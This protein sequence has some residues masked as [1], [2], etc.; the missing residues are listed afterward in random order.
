MLLCITGIRDVLIITDYV[1]NLCKA[2]DLDH[3]G[4]SGGI[5]LHTV[6]TPQLDATNP[7]SW[8]CNIPFMKKAE[9][10]YFILFE[11][12]KPSLQALRSLVWEH[13]SERQSSPSTLPSPDLS[14]AVTLNIVN[15]STTDEWHEVV[16]DRLTIPIVGEWE[17]ELD[18][19]LK[20]I[21]QLYLFLHYEKPRT[22]GG[23]ELANQVAEYWKLYAF[24]GGHIG[25]AAILPMIWSDVIGYGDE[26][27]KS[28]LDQVLMDQSFELAQAV[29]HIIAQPP[30]SAVWC[31]SIWD[32]FPCSSVE[33]NVRGRLFGALEKNQDTMVED[34]SQ[35]IE[36]MTA[37]FEKWGEGGCDCA[38]GQA[39]ELRAT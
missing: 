30:E 32:V 7:S 14:P 15:S 10:I 22:A 16:T 37:L 1:S 26:G 11:K 24:C 38:K 21:R 23:M 20:R 35:A 18:S 17:I 4:S 29:G 12:L 13:Y 34:E 2:R 28:M 5:G 3:K 8:S 6:D 27:D 36:I 39:E 19:R 9:G 33:N 31:K 25:L